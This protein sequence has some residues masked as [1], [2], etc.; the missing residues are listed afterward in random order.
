MVGNWREE[1]QEK[2]CSAADAAQRIKSGD[3]IF[4]AGFSA[5]PYDFTEALA[6]RKDELRDVEYYGCLSPY[7]FRIFDGEFKGHI[8]YST[9]FSGGYERCAPSKHELPNDLIH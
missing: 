3:S 1:Y 4:T 8:N 5:M 7:C 6:A 2:L 9:I